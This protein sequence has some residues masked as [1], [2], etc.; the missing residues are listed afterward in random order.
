VTP[1]CTASVDP[2]SGDTYVVVNDL[3]FKKQYYGISIS[4]IINAKAAKRVTDTKCESSV[5]SA[6][7]P[8]LDEGTVQ[9]M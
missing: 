1:L 2:V 3:V 4:G 9:S 6:F 5:N 7:S 8:I